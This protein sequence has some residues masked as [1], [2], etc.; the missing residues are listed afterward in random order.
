MLGLAGIRAPADERGTC[1]R[2]EEEEYKGRGPN[3]G[4]L[5]ETT[6]VGSSGSQF[7][8][9]GLTFR[10]IVPFSSFRVRLRRARV[11]RSRAS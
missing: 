7:L 6:L 10:M 9:V 2:V 3:L 5:L 11:S 8:C 4:V 1:S